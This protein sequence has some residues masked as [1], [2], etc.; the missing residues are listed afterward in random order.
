MSIAT[1]LSS[2]FRRDLTRLGQHLEAFPTEE[3][4]WQ[5]LPG[6]SNPGGTLTLHL[7]GNLREYIGR[8]LGGIEYKRDR[9]MEFTARKVAKKELVRRIA[10]VREIVPMVV[11]RLSAEQMDEQFP[12]VIQG[13]PMSTRQFLIHLLGHLNWHLG[14]MD[15]LRRILTQGEAIMPAT[16]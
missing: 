10:E 8:Q 9:P 4:L 14:E 5:V 13:V 16:L 11:E 15:Y 7:E 12:E 1:E 2:L 3:S 6:V